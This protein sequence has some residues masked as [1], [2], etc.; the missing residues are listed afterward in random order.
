MEGYEIFEITTRVFGRLTKSTFVAVASVVGGVLSMCLLKGIVDG[1]FLHRTPS[2]YA[3]SPAN[4]YLCTIG[5]GI[6]SLTF[7]L[8]IQALLQKIGWTG[9]L[10]N[11]ATAVLIGFPI[12]VWLGEA[13]SSSVDDARQPLF[14]QL[15][16]RVA[17]MKDWHA[18][19]WFMLFY[20][21]SGAIIF[22]L[23]R[24]PDKDAAKPLP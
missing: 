17:E 8:P 24:R 5:W 15:Q 13:W 4:L 10:S 12:G 1:L 7:G 3:L 20:L 2:F 21:I 6:P 9:L 19:G 11:L 22:W 16:D 18:N 23:I 14:T